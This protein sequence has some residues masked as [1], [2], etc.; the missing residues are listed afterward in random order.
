MS[1]RKD[2]REKVRRAIS[3]VK[4]SPERAHERQRLLLEGCSCAEIARREGKSPTTISEW[5]G[6]N[7]E[8]IQKIVEAAQMRMI[9]ENLDTVVE[10]QRMKIHLGNWKLKAAIPDKEG[11]IKKELGSED[12]LVMELADKAEDRLM[13]S[14]GLASSVS[15][16][17]VIQNIF[18]Q[19][20]NI[21]SDGMSKM[22]AKY[23]EEDVIESG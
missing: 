22:L 18:N 2:G 17:T 9:D 11:V 16:S 21:I 8:E 20:N 12:K 10:N 14:I 23:S 15:Q 5:V 4:I 13:K 7:K 3:G 1:E 19:Q 6:R